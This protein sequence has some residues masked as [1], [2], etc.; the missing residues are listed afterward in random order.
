[1]IIRAG[2]RTFSAATIFMESI[3]KVCPSAKIFGEETGQAIYNYTGLAFEELKGIN[4]KFAFPM[5]LDEYTPL[6]ELKK[7]TDSYYRGIM[8]DVE[9]YE[10]FEDFMK[11]EDTIYN[12]IFDYFNK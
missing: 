3:L 1:M 4:C 2:G 9:V 11:G 5:V 7:R 12:A 10:R 6:T 8:P